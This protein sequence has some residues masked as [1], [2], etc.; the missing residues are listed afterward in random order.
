MLPQDAKAVSVFDDNYL[1]FLNEIQADDVATRAWKGL[2]RLEHVAITLRE[3]ADPQQ[4]FES[5]NSTGAPLANYELI[6][7][8]VLM[9][10]S[11]SEQMEIEDSSWIPIEENTGDFI[12]SFW[13]DYLIMKTGRD[14]EFTGQHG[15]YEVF[16]KEF[17]PLR[18]D[19]LVKR[20]EEWRDYS[21]I[22][23]VLL[24]PIQAGDEDIQT[25]LGYG[26]TF[27]T[28]M[29]PLLLAVYR[30]YLAGS[31]DKRRL[32]E[33]M[34]RVQSLQIRRMVVGQSRDHLAAQLCRRR[35]RGARDPIA[36]I[37]R[38]TPS[39]DRVGH[40]LRYRTL[41]HAG[42][43]LSRIER[44]RF[45]G[46]ALGA[47]FPAG[48]E[49]EHIFPQGPTA[50]WSGDGI[51]L[52]GAFSEEERS[53][54]REL[55]STLG[56]VAL[57][58]QPLNAGASNKSFHDKKVYYR[59]SRIPSTKALEDLDVWDVAAIENRATALTEQFLAIWQRPQVEELPGELVPI[60][61]VQKRGGWYQDWKTEFEYVQFRDEVWEVHH[62]LELR[63]R[64]YQHLLNT[65]PERIRELDRSLH[66]DPHIR[67]T[68]VPGFR[69]EPIG[70]AQ[71]LY[72]GWVP[73]Y[74]LGDIQQ[75][76]DELGLADEVFVKYTADEE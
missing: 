43:V 65:N 70:D 71:Y 32:I 46:T 54:Y 10:L 28:A 34:E 61:D 49:I 53:R 20:A 64:L 29:Y 68:P 17:P 38:R 56:N 37:L 45:P 15:V 33:I 13:R 4:I 41:P 35:L 73:Q 51:R 27:G 76:L 57:L 24:D 63:V 58:E 2:N 26:N 18:F 16:R 48:F 55:L 50:A 25:Q 1:F 60:L 47:E 31:I 69:Y 30:D 40:S 11:H 75:L 14:T 67:E 44:V 23:R 74:L 9:G 62:I 19:D 72:N 5:L 59:Q 39:D 6:H 21:D 12:D 7:N 22:Y 66:G 52:W 8:Y 36:D 3:N 42:Y